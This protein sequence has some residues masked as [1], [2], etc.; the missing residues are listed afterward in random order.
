MEGVLSRITAA[1]TASVALLGLGPA[2][3]SAQDPTITPTVTPTVSPTPVPTVTPTPTPVPPSKRSKSV[4]KVYKDYRDDGVIEACDHTK[5]ALKK[6]L[7]ELDPAADV[8]TPDLRPALEAAIEQHHKAGCD[9][10]GDGK[11]NSQDVKPGPTGSNGSNGTPSPTPTVVPTVV[12]TPIPTTPPS[13][14]TVKPVP[15]PKHSPPT[16]GDVVPLT[17]APTPAPPAAVPPA[18]EPSGPAPTPSVVYRNGDDPVP[19]SL[20]VLAGVL[21]LLALLALGY[22]ALTRLGWADERLARPRRAWREAA[23]RTGGTW[24]DFSDWIR[25]GR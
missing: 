14:G 13:T 22:V 15:P 17:P 5:K 25:V 20:L 1:L 16:K 21:A 7:K 2:G 19:I 6:T 11:V 3:A 8:D 10:N 12:P 24:A 23:F 4:K 9:R 18:A